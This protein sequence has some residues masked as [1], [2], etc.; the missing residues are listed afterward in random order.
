LHPAQY[1]LLQGSSSGEAW[2]ALQPWL[3]LRAQPGGTSA[4]LP[5]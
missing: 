1:P 4:L 3:A 5:A 2:E